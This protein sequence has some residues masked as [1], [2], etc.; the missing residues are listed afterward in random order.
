MNGNG[1]ERPIGRHFDELTEQEFDGGEPERSL[2]GGRNPSFVEPR[3]RHFRDGRVMAKLRHIPLTMSEANEFIERPPSPPR[4]VVFSQ[5]FPRGGFGRKGRE[6]LLFSLRGGRS[7]GGRSSG[8]R[9]GLHGGDGNM[10]NMSK[11]KHKARPEAPAPRF[12]GDAREPRKADSPPRGCL[13]AGA[14]ESARGL[15]SRR[16]GGVEPDRGPSPTG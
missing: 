9:L 10:I 4:Q 8:V 1:N 11:S 6:R 3:S 15:G 16:G 2:E 7:S 14:G 13:Q 12:G 5:V